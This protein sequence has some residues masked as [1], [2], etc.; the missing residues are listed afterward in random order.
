MSETTLTTTPSKTPA[1]PEKQQGYT[2]RLDDGAMQHI[3]SGLPTE[4]QDDVMWLAIYLRERCNRQLS[5]LEGVTTKLGFSTTASV[6]YK[7]LTG[8]YFKPD[9][10]RKGKLI[11]SI[12]NFQ[13]VVAKLRSH[14]RIEQVTGK[15]PFIETPTWETIENY[16][17]VRRAPDRICKFGLI[18]GPTGAQKSESFREY[19]RRNNHGKCVH[20]ETPH[21]GSMTQ[22]ITDLAAK[23]GTSVWS[24][25]ANKLA[26]IYES[27]DRSRT[28]I[29]DNVQRLYDAKAGGDQPVFNFLQKLQDDKDCTVILSITPDFEK[30]MTMEMDRGYFEQFE[31]RCGGRGAFLRLAEKAS[32][33]DVLAICDGFALEFDR[34][35]D[36]GFLEKLAHAP[37]R[38]RIL[39]AALQDAQALA[40]DEEKPLNISHV[41]EVRGEVQE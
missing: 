36:I 38:I 25:Q 29:V 14:F 39:F 16:I 11:G 3:I 33:E 4:V 9:P 21:R 12:P 18:I 27:V 30:M 41:R 28:I 26:Q 7:I 17:T 23:Y 19:V 24:N 37:G 31:G 1:A 15:I 13:Q 32:R 40:K 34:Q 35:K 10:K 8:R 20:L 2:L 6:F 5:V 22:F